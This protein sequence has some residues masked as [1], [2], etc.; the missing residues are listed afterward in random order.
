MAGR[1]GV[2]L[3]QQLLGS[4]ARASILPG[5]TVRGG[6]LRSIFTSARCF[7]DEEGAK[8]PYTNE[9]FQGVTEVAKVMISENY[10][11]FSVGE[12]QALGCLHER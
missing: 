1:C 5:A 4:G 10:L 7:S 9:Y 2:S 12:E 6:A 8:P 3:C 11:Y